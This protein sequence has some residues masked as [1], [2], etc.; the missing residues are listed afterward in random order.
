MPFYTL[1]FQRSLKIHKTVYDFSVNRRR[2]YLEIP[3]LSGVV[4]DLTDPWLC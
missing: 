4:V 3:L 2:D 1:L